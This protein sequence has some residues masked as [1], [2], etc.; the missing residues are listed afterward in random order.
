METTDMEC[1]LRDSS[2]F[3]K[4]QAQLSFTDRE[5]EV[6]SLCAQI[7][8]LRYLDKSGAVRLSKAL[9]NMEWSTAEQLQLAT[10]V[11]TRSQLSGSTSKKKNSPEA[12]ARRR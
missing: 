4:V 11:G 10:A 5:T 9:A 1:A 8:E 7:K 6:A 12:T 3:L 2:E